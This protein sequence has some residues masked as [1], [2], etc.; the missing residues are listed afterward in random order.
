MAPNLSH[1]N[2]LFSAI[3]AITVFFMPFTCGAEETP[4]TQEQL[5]KI[6]EIMSVITADK[7]TYTGDELLR[8]IGEK[9]PEQGFEIE[10]FLILKDKLDALVY[11]YLDRILIKENRESLPMLKSTL[12]GLKEEHARLSGLLGRV[13]ALMESAIAGTEVSKRYEATRKELEFVERKLE[14]LKSRLSEVEG[15]QRFVYIEEITHFERIR[16]EYALAMVRLATE[17]RA[18]LDSVSEIDR[19]N[20]KVSA[21]I[22]LESLR[23]DI[24]E[25]ERLIEEAEAMG[26]WS[27]F[28]DRFKARPASKE[29]FLLVEANLDKLLKYVIKDI[30]LPGRYE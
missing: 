16:D 4:L 1:R 29:E 13:E 5:D 8:A 22:K 30:G 26:D 10:E 28:S 7:V 25:I 24:A 17:R 19:Q 15:S 3:L 23:T 20:L 6:L 11:S 14:K 18:I 21:E 12:E 27:Q 2:G 9:A